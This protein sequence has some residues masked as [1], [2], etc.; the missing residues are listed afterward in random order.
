VIQTATWMLLQPSPGGLQISTSHTTGQQVV[1]LAY[2]IIVCTRV[3]SEHTVL[4]ALLQNL[5]RHNIASLSRNA[6]PC[7]AAA[8]ALAILRGVWLLIETLDNMPPGAIHCELATG[9]GSSMC[10]L[11]GRLGDDALG[12]ACR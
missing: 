1:L 9:I 5:L 8:P 4:I 6:D 2:A 10:C 3:P 11:W 7:L 12:L